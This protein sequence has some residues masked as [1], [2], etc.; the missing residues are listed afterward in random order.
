LRVNRGAAAAIPNISQ[1]LKFIQ[2]SQIS[3]PKSEQMPSALSDYIYVCS[4]GTSW[5]QSQISGLVAFLNI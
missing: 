3:L 4:I 5:R 2:I 1:F